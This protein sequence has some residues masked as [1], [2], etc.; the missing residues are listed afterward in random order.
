MK[1]KKCTGCNKLPKMSKKDG[2]WTISCKCGPE[3]T[4]V[5]T[6]DRPKEVAI[7][8]Y[9]SLMCQDK[10]NDIVITITIPADKENTPITIS[11][12]GPDDS[13]DRIDE[14]RSRIVSIL[15]GFGK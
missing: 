11:C 9:N 12:K 13:F 3:R 14:V 4:V 10:K 6:G 5:V 7:A 15:K 1:L 8:H 2:V